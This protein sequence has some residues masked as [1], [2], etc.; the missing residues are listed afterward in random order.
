MLRLLLQGCTNFL[1]YE[2]G[3]EPF[4]TPV[5]LSSTLLMINFERKEAIEGFM[6]HNLERV[7]EGFQTTELKSRLKSTVSL[8]VALHIDL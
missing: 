4:R 3:Q 7:L 1:V 8:E 2:M 5:W 6:I